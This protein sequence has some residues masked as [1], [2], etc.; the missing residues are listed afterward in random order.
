MGGADKKDSDDIRP[1]ASRR[2]NVIVLLGLSGVFLASLILPAPDGDYFTICA[3]K[4]VTGLPCPGCGL[5]HSFCA[6]ARGHL[7]QALGY[8]M[9]GP[10]VFLVFV[11]LWIRS[12]CALTGWNRAALAL[13]LLGRRL[14]LAR[15]FVT[16]FVLFGVGRIVYLLIY[17]P[18]LLN[19]SPVARL[20]A[21]ITH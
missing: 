21:W 3:F 11:L 2:L 4:N 16:A 10:A 19:S 15:V 8:N 1:P 20:V 18:D 14:R 12:T 9:L 6:L 7:A 17:R 5:T 13:D